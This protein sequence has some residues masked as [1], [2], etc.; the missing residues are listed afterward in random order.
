[1]SSEH[2]DTEIYFD[3][4]HIHYG[5]DN[6]K[7][8]YKAGPARN[9][10]SEDDVVNFFEQLNILVQ[11]PEIRETKLKDVDKHFIVFIFDGNKKF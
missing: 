2:F 11:R 5:W 9:A 7:R 10:Y 3:L 1:M 8:D 6:E 4:K